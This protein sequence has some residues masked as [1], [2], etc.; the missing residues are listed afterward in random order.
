M[1]QFHK[2]IALSAFL[3]FMIITHKPSVAQEPPHPPQNGH[4]Q[5]GNQS[6]SGGSA[7]IGGGLPILLLL[8]VFYGTAVSVNRKKQSTDTND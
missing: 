1:K 7:P 3:V 5:L 4:G 8:S 2:I 6:P